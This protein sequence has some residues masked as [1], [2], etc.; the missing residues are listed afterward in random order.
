[1]VLK[2]GDS[3]F[4]FHGSASFGV[5]SGHLWRR[6]ED[7]INASGNEMKFIQESECS[8]MHLLTLSSGFAESLSVTYRSCF[9]KVSV[10]ITD[11]S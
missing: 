9:L 3:V 6:T 7:R 10:C 8:K 1:M 11:F 4:D 2:Q 5:I